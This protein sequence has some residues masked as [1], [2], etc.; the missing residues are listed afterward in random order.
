MDVVR[1]DGAR[2][3]SRRG[4]EA[5]GQPQ[6]RLHRDSGRTRGALR[7]AIARTAAWWRPRWTEPVH[8]TTDSGAGTL[9]YVSTVDR[10]APPPRGHSAGGHRPPPP[11]LAG[12]RPQR[13]G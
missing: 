10:A 11:P 13:R 2:D 9:R 1:T 8:V 7:H 5:V 3:C 6:V 12:S 4:R